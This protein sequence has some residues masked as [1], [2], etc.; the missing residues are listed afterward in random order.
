MAEARVT[1]L[2]AKEPPRGAAGPTMVP[3]WPVV[4][5]TPAA[6]EGAPP[7]APCSAVKSYRDSP[8]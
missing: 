7:A 3:A 5:A 4:A 6:R 8:T 2:L 1:T